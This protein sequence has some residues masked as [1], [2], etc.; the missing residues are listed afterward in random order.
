MPDEPPSNPPVT[1]LGLLDSVP[2]VR[3]ADRDWRALASMRHPV[4]VALW[5][6]LM[7]PAEELMSRESLLTTTPDPTTKHPELTSIP[8]VIA[9]AEAAVRK[10][11]RGD[12]QAWSLVADRIEGKAGL[13]KD[14]IDP[15]EARRRT[16]VQATI[17]A[18]VRGFVD[19]RLND[20]ASNARNITDIEPVAQSPHDTHRQDSDTVRRAEIMEAAR[21]EAEDN[22][23]R[24]ESLVQSNDTPEERDLTDPHDPRRPNGHGP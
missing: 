6:A 11:I 24:G 12:M 17:E 21:R 10:G 23:G 7:R 9:W 5:L 13:R 22:Q 1:N 19:G 2:G 14:D 16:D 20:P 8:A 3:L 18:V 15:E 4:K